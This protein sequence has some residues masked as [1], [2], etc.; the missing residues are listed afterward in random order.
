MKTNRILQLIF[1]IFAV[2]VFASC[3]YEFI[4]PEY[5]P[6]PNPEDTISFAQEVVPIFQS[7]GCTVCHKPGGF[8]GL[9]LTLPHAYNNLMSSNLVNTTNPAASKIYTYPHPTTGT[10]NAK[11]ANEAEA[12]IILQW[13][14]QGALNN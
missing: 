2:V 12:Q 4:K 6:P 14:E 10:H 13:I 8:G 5:T 7:N 3:E 1:L 11:Y 9:D